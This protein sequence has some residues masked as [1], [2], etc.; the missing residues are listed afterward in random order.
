MLQ[1]LDFLKMQWT[2]FTEKVLPA[3]GIPGT[4]RDPGYNKGW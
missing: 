2:K 1:L 3:G 4:Y